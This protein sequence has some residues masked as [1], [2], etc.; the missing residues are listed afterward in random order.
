MAI[1][2]AVAAAMPAHLCIRTAPVDEEVLPFGN[3][4][5]NVI[6][7]RARRALRPICW[8]GRSSVLR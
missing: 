4:L 3:A 2:S 7:G 6:S 1:G 8:A 5:G